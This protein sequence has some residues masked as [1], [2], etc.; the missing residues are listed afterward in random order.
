MFRILMETGALNSRREGRGAK[1]SSLISPWLP[2]F[3]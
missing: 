3:I 1:F 2:E